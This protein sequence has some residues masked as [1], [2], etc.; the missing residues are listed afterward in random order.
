MATAHNPFITSIYTADPSAHVWADGRLY[1]YPSHDIAPPRG[2]DLMDKYH[3]FS[4]NDMVNWTDH[5]EILSAAQVDW[6][7][8]DG[9]FMWAPDCAYKNG[10]YYYY[11]PHPSGDDW[12][13]SW[14]IG[15]ATS[16]EPA[17]NFNV[18]G[19]I[20]NLKS[21]IDPCVF[22]DDDG[23]AYLYYGG[24]GHCEG[25]KLKENMVEIEGDMEPMEGLQEFHEAVWVHKRNGLY[26]L[27]YADN[28]NNGGNQLRYA[29]SENPLGPWKYKGVYLKPTGSTTNHGSIVEYKG[30][31]YAFFHNSM[32]SGNDW[33]RSVCFD[34]LFYN[35]NGSILLVNQT[36]S[37]G[38]PFN[39]EAAAVPGIL[40]VEDY[41]VGGQGIAYSDSDTDN[42]GKEYRTGEAVDIE[43]SGTGKYNI[44]WTNGGEWLE[45]TINVAETS[46]YKVTFYVASPDGN[47]SLHLNLDGKDITGSI[48]IGST[49][50]WQN[51]QQVSVDNVL[52]NKGTQVIQLFEETGG[53]NID[54][55]EFTKNTET[56][57]VHP[58]STIKTIELYPNPADP[59]VITIQLP[60]ENT[61]SAIAEIFD[62]QGRLISGDI[63]K[64]I[65]RN[66]AQLDITNLKSGN[67]IIKVKCNSTVYYGKLI[68][69]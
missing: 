39:G 65:E 13:N 6:G 45:Y 1:V 3:V 48:K 28:N 16:S 33:L 17:S 67:Y 68:V 44:S 64:Y 7:R 20:E 58:V 55:M 40:E 69:K 57:N 36:K 59:S 30:Q 61:S 54:K 26:Y 24:G 15:V 53:F 19:Y 21:M 8:A 22:V 29:T 25:G 60:T 27:S 23:Q 42:N 35:D 56:T 5:G 31:W 63:I 37:H 38:T 4:T 41:D 11:F 9:G 43:K 10:T 46:N 50:G 66:T 62:F 18:Q 12:S 47:A 52:L 14:K 32:L 34:S 51:Y 2:C 49:G